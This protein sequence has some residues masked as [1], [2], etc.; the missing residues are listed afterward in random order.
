VVD[1]KR[2]I[3][4]VK[5]RNH[6]AS[7]DYKDVKL[8]SSVEFGST[9]LQSLTPTN[10]I[11]HDTDIPHAFAPVFFDSSDLSFNLI[12]HPSTAYV[13][14]II[15]MGPFIAFSDKDANFWRIVATTTGTALLMVFLLDP[16]RSLLQFLARCRKMTRAAC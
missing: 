11:S 13:N 15:G 4:E 5:D 6:V 9:S 3:A 12:R 8:M 14:A 16:F 2:R 7:D 10:T 1:E